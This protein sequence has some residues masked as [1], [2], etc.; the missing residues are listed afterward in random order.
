MP[1]FS[2]ARSKAGRKRSG[3]G[4]NLAVLALCLWS[5][6]AE[7]AE[8]GLAARAERLSSPRLALASAVAVKTSAIEKRKSKESRRLTPDEILSPRPAGFVASASDCRCSGA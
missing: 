4:H 6:W 1:V 5:D 2:E 8:A 7:I 3:S